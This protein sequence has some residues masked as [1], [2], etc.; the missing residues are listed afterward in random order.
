MQLYLPP[1]LVKK[2]VRL[3]LPIA[4]AYLVVVSGVLVEYVIVGNELGPTGIGAVGLA[5]TFS[6]VLIL[7]F[8]AVEIAVQAIASRRFGEGDFAA[9]GKVLNNGLLVSF[10]LG[11][12]LTIF[13]Y[14]LGSRVFSSSDSNAEIQR[15]AYQ[16][17]QWRLPNMPFFMAVL[18]MIGFCNAISKPRIPMAVY[19]VILVLNGV[20][21]YALVGGRLGA[22]RLGIAG[23]GL[24][25]TISALTGFTLF[26]M[27]LRERAIRA[28]YGT[29]RFR[30]QID[31]K[32]LKGLMK[33]AWPVAVQ[34][35]FSNFGVYLFVLINAGVDD[36]GVSLSAST[37]ARNVGYITYLP[38]LG[39]G[40]AAAT[41]VGQYLGADK[42]REAKWGGFA[43]WGLGAAYMVTAGL[44]FLLFR[45]QIVDLFLR[46]VGGGGAGEAAE[47]L[48]LHPQDVRDY[49]AKLLVIVASYQIFES[50]NTI[51]GK[52]LQGAG[53]TMFVMKATVAFQWLF[54]LPLAYTLAIPLGMGGFGAL[55]ALA[56]QLSG[57][58][59]LFF[60]KFQSG[61]WQGK[62]V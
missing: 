46:N 7:S 44:F 39:F 57:V 53:A 50:A 25:Q 30:G 51:L 11:I 54:F 15:L 43:C 32:V 17:F 48:K 45:H 62:K 21:C 19:A 33:L 56:I 5:G 14:L 1:E 27:L 23:A 47:A 24:A 41:I 3:A 31:K 28:R 61:T 55:L 2:A 13:L 34:Q 58:A 8:H 4:A 18:A 9:A 52:A 36:D 37:I 12:P 38:S 35:F 26:F 49:A 29:L 22:P 42:P 40:L 59:A 6:L 16:Y 10:G 60:W 20:L